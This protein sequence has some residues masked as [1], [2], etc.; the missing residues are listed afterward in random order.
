VGV[1]EVRGE[2]LLIGIVVAE[3]KAKEA[4]QGL[5]ERGFLVNA[6][7]ENVIRL[8]PSYLVSESQIMKFA[9]AFNEVCEEIYRG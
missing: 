1:K 4:A 8:A 9:T 2:G 5:Q 6:A 3:L 7:N